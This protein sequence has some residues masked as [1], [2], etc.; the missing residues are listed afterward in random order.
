MSARGPATIG[1]VAGT[2]GKQKTA[3][4]MVLSMGVIVLAG[5]VMWLFI[6]HEDGKP[7]SSG[8][9]TGWSC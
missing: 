3:R 5:L 2:K 7:T 1:G 6:P 4:D 8:S 9:T